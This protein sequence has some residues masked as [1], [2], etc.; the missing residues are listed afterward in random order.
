MLVSPA[1]QRGEGS[2]Q[3]LVSPVG[4]VQTVKYP[5]SISMAPPFPSIGT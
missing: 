4:A 1:L 3:Q 5:Y 2:K